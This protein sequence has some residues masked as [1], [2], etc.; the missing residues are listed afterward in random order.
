MTKIRKQ[1]T[2]LPRSTSTPV[3]SPRRQGWRIALV[4]VVLGAV[5]FALAYGFTV[6]WNT[7][8]PE[9]D[10]PGMVWIP[11]GKFVMGSEGMRFPRSEQPAH[12]VR[13][14]GF[15]MD[16]TEVTNAQF[17]EFVEATG[18]VTT[19]E[20]K[21]DWEEL[22]KQVRPGTPKP[23]DSELVP[24]SMVFSPPSKPT[25][26]ED[27]RRWWKYVPGACWKHPEGPGSSIEEKDDHPV[28]HVSWHDAAAYAKWAGKRLPTEAEWE[29]AARGGLTGKR[30]PWGNKKPT[31]DAPRCNIWHGVFPHKNTKPGSDQRTMPVKSF[32]PNAYGLY[33]MA[34][35]VWEWCGDWYRPDEYARRKLAGVLSVDP[36]GPKAS[37]DPVHGSA[38]RRVTRGGSFLC[39]EAYCESYR[40][41][42]RRG[43]D[44]DTGMS[45]IGFRCVMPGK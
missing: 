10:P 13:V 5:S 39:H 32:A 43:T 20:Q 23:P 18:Y 37:L 29:F 6:W 7:T 33:D 9:G 24:G 22:K 27:F 45:H 34:G 1:P 16:E 4:S 19:A 30:Y 11:G 12:E 14:T 40:P 44:P 38:P 35:N 21:P 36:T 25:G 28:V 41:G 17:R 2:Q 42:A 26:T 8:P 3:E 15:W 31:E